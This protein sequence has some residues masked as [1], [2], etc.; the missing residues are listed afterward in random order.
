MKFKVR[1][2]HCITSLLIIIFLAGI[3]ACQ[4]VL[5][6]SE[7]AFDA[8]N[9]KPLAD[10]ESINPDTIIHYTVVIENLGPEDALDV[11]LTD[12]LPSNIKFLKVLDIPLGANIITQP[13]PSLDSKNPLQTDD[14]E[15][16][17]GCILPGENNKDIVTVEAR[18]P[19]KEEGPIALYNYILVRAMNINDNIF[20]DFKLLLH[21]H[22][23]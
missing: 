8:T 14:I 9:N 18:A 12:W 3:C 13:N 23:E 6:V 7:T 19:P 5:K 4:P 1:S 20:E 21:T 16:S 17:L 11:H 10:G 15:I 22:Y 2:Y